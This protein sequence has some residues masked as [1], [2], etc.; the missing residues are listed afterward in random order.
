MSHS[1]IQK[2]EKEVKKRKKGK[3]RTPIAH[4]L[5]ADCVSDIEKWNRCGVYTWDE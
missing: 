4:F 1:K 3:E 2:A 5:T